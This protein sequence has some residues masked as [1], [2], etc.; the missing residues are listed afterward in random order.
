MATKATRVFPPISLD[1][2]SVPMPKPVKTKKKMCRLNLIVSVELALSFVLFAA[3]LFK[4]Y[5]RVKSE[6]EQDQLHAA[7]LLPPVVG[8]N[9]EVGSIDE[10]PSPKATQRIV[11]ST[12]IF[13][14]DTSTDFGDVSA[15]SSSGVPT[16][17]SGTM[18]KLAPII[19]AISAEDELW[20]DN[21]QLLIGSLQSI[22]GDEVTPPTQY[23]LTPNAIKK[24]SK[25]KC[26]FSRS[27]DSFNEG[28]R[29]LN[30]EDHPSSAPRVSTA[31]ASIVHI[32]EIAQQADLSS[33][34]VPYAPPMMNEVERFMQRVS[35]AVVPFV[36]CVEVD[37]HA[38][39]SSALVPYAQMVR[40]VPAPVIGQFALV[41]YK[42]SHD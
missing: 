6:E 18:R 29:R 28:M 1:A 39:S 36:R 7:R 20:A 37:Q 34:L 21:R 32:R 24:P 5:V 16:I 14:S 25:T 27:M 13:P 26:D 3:R 9:D 4:G 12:M 30:L 22:S 11:S 17:S 2:S 19:E 40:Y 31:V 10:M 33:A 38:E 35:T 42:S 8:S 23:I 41:P 15:L